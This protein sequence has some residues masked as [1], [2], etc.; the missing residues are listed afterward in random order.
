MHLPQLLPPQTTCTLC[1]LHLEAKS[2]GI[3]TL[4]LPGSPPPVASTPAFLLIGQNPGYHEDVAGLPIVG[5]TGAFTR[6]VLC[7]LLPLTRH[8]LGDPH[9]PL[10]T[11][12]TP[13]R[14]A[15]NLLSEV[16]GLPQPDGPLFTTYFANTA[17]CFTAADNPPPRAYAQCSKHHL[18]DDIRALLAFHSHLHILALGAPAATFTLKLL[19]H[20]KAKLSTAFSLSG[21][22]F[23]LPPSPTPI[24]FFASFHPAHILRNNNM[25]R[26]FSDHISLINRHIRGILPPITKPHFI[27]LRSPIHDHIRQRT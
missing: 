21:R 18:L 24:T 7:R 20:K 15:W 9:A 10:K 6:L 26:P 12:S 14:S 4:H 1:P 3:P 25:I 22:S 13:P 5:I 17:R 11:R 19:G 27:P 8:H 16:P 23:T 2:V